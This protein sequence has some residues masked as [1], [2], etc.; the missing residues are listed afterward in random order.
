MV[1]NKRQ[2]GDAIAQQENIVFQSNPLATTAN[3]GIRKTKP[4][5]QAE[6]VCQKQQ[7]QKRCRHHKDQAEHIAAVLN[8]LEQGC[9]GFFSVKSKD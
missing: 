9:H 1:L 7:Q 2:L 5:T 8:S 6:R 3:F 4:N